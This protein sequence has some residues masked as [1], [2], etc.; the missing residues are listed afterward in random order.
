MRATEN[1]EVDDEILNEIH[2]IYECEVEYVYSYEN[3]S[4]GVVECFGVI[5]HDDQEDSM[6]IENITYSSGAKTHEQKLLLE[7]FIIANEE[8]IKEQ[9]YEL[10]A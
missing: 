4:I 10:N 3:N 8:K 1:I 2:D 9:I 5:S 7:A 6:V